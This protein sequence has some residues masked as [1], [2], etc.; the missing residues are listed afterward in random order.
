MHY[1][2]VIKK[3]V[4]SEKSLAMGEQFKYTFIVDKK[5][6]KNLVKIAIENIFNVNVNKVNIINT[7]GV[8]KRFKG[9]IGRT[10]DYKKAIVTIDKGQTIDLT[11]SI[12]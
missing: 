6:N 2:D 3:P 4:L 9:N 5:S 12:K 7:C 8:T 1:Y 11:G 10:S